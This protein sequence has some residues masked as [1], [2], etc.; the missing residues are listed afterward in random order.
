M[1]DRPGGTPVS[2]WL[3]AE[4]DPDRGL[5]ATQP[6]DGFRGRSRTLVRA[7]AAGRDRH[8]QRDLG[9]APPLPEGAGGRG[10]A[11]NRDRGPLR[12]RGRAP[13]SNPAVTPGPRSPVVTVTRSP[14][15]AGDRVCGRS[16]RTPVTEYHQ[17]GRSP[18]GQA[19]RGPDV[20]QRPGTVPVR[21]VPRPPADAG[22]GSGRLRRRARVLPPVWWGDRQFL[23]AAA[24]HQPPRS[25]CT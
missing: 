24:P 3:A 11:R 18:C 23:P 13:G 6:R 2:R 12:V 5:A 21:S 7:G 19:G 14:L 10:A 9:E 20:R 8:G 4:E 16:C 17:A 15:R 1:R 22:L 25:T